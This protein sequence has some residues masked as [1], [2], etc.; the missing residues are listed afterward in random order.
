[1][2]DFQNVIGKYLLNREKNKKYLALLLALC[3]LVS[4]A[5]P[6]SLIQPADSLTIDRSHLATQLS[7]APSRPAN[8]NGWFDKVQTEVPDNAFNFSDKITATTV[9]P[10]DG[11]SVTDDGNGNITIQGGGAAG[12]NVNFAI[13]YTANSDTVSLEHPCIYYQLPEGVTVPTEYYGSAMGVIDPDYSAE[14]YAGY[15]TISKDGLIVIQFTDEYINYLSTTHSYTG[16]I[17]FDGYVVAGESASGDRVLEIGNTTITVDFDEANYNIHKQATNVQNN[18]NGTAT[19]TWQVKVGCYGNN[20]WGL[21]NMTVTDAKFPADKNSVTINPSGWGSWNGNTYTFNQFQGGYGQQFPKEATFTFTE[22]VTEDQLNA[23]YSSD[24]KKLQNTASYRYE[25]YNWGGGTTVYENTVTAD[26][27]FSDTTV[28]KGGTPDYMTGPM[29]NKVNWTITLDNP[30]GAN[31]SGYKISDEMLKKAVG[32]ITVLDASGNAVTYDATDIANGNIVLGTTDASK[33][34]IKYQTEATIGQTYNNTVEVKYPNSENAL[35]KVPASVEYSNPYI[36]DKNA[37]GFD[38]ES[39]KAF[40][41]VTVKTKADTMTLANHTFTDD[42]F[43]NISMNDLEVIYV[44]SGSNTSLT[45]TATD[46]SISF[47]DYGML[48]KSGST[49]SIADGAQGGLHEIKLRYSTTISDTDI[50]NQSTVSNDIT[51]ASGNTDTAYNELKTPYTLNKSGSYDASTQKVTWTIT[52]KNGASNTATLNGMVLTDAA[53]AD[54]FTKNFT[55]VHAYQPS[56]TDIGGTQ[57]GDVVTFGNGSTMTLSGTTLTFANVDGK[58]VNEVKFTYQTDVSSADMVS[59]KNQTNEVTANK[60]VTGTTK[61]EVQVNNP[62]QLDKTGAFDASTGEVVWTVTVKNTAQNGSLGGV[63]LTDEAFANIDA[64]KIKITTSNYN[65]NNA[66]YTVSGNTITFTNGGTATFDGNTLTFSE[67][68]NVGELV[69]QYTTKVSDADFKNQVAQTNK[70]ED[71]YGHVKEPSVAV[72][73]PYG[74]TKRG[75]F[76]PATG[77]ITWTVEVTSDANSSLNGYVLTDEAFKDLVNGIN[78]TSA[79]SYSRGWEENMTILNSAGSSIGVG[80]QGFWIDNTNRDVVFATVNLDAAAGTVT[81]TN[82]N[83]SNSQYV[84]IHK[85]TFTYETEVD[86][87]DIV[88]QVTQTNRISDNKGHVAEFPVTPT[89][90][91]QLSKSGQYDGEHKG[92]YWIIQ[93]KN[94]GKGTIAGVELTDAKFEGLTIE[95]FEVLSAGLDGN[96]TFTAALNAEKTAINIKINGAAAGSIFMSAE[97]K[98][99]VSDDA[100]FD[101]LR[102]RYYKALTDEELKA[103]HA[104]NTVTD[105]KTDGPASASVTVSSPYTL[106]KGGS[107]NADEGKINWNINAGINSVINTASLDK[108]VLTDIMLARLTSVDE[109][110][111]TTASYNGTTLTVMSRDTANN[112]ITLGANNTEYATMTFDFA[113]GTV[114]FADKTEDGLT[115]LSHVRLEYQ[116]TP[117]ADERAAGKA[118]NTVYSSDKS[119]SAEVPVETRSSLNKFF[120]TPTKNETIY[121]NDGEARNLDWHLELVED[122]GFAAKEFLV[123]TLTQST[124]GSHYI[125]KAQ[126]D[127]IIIA[128]GVKAADNYNETLTAGTDYVIKF[129]D[130]SGAEITEWTDTTTAVKFTIDFNE[131]VDTQNLRYMKVAYKTTAD[132]SKI[133]VDEN[134]VDKVTANFGND[135]TFGSKSDTDNGFY[136]ERYPA[137]YV[138]KV[139]ITAEKYWQDNS[140]YTQSGIQVQLYQSLAGTDNWIAYGD[141]VTLTNAKNWKHTWENL[142]KTETT[143]TTQYLYKVEE[144]KVDNY[145]TSYNNNGGINSGTIGITN[146]PLPKV[147]KVYVASTGEIRG[148]SEVL[149]KDL[150]TVKINNVDYYIMQWKI[151]PNPMQS[152][153]VDTLPAGFTLLTDSN[154]TEKVYGPFVGESWGAENSI[155]GWAQTVTYQDNGT[156]V[157]FKIDDGAKKYLRYFLKIPVA[158]LEKQ[159]EDNNGSIP[160]TNTVKAEGGQENPVTIT[161]SETASS[162]DEGKD[163]LTK[164]G[165][166]TL[167]PGRLKYTILVNPDGKNLSNGDTIDIHDA[168]DLLGYTGLSAE[169]VAALNASLSD[170]RVEEVSVAEDMSYSVLRALSSSEYQYTLDYKLSEVITTNYNFTETDKTA[171]GTNANQE[172]IAT[173]CTPGDKITVV[174][175]AEK[176]KTSDIYNIYLQYRGQWSDVSI[177]ATSTSRDEVAGTKTFVYTIPEGVTT[178]YLRSWAGNDV[179]ITSITATSTRTETTT[180]DLNISVPDERPLLVTYYYDITGVDLKNNDI[181]KADNTASFDTGNA[182][183]SDTADKDEFVVVSTG[184]TVTAN[185]SPVIKKTSTNDYSLTLN[186]ATFKLAY[187][188]AANGWVFA[189]GATEATSGNTT[190]HTPVWDAEANDN[191][192]NEKFIPANAYAFDIGTISMKLDEGKL[193]K[194]IETDVPEAYEGSNLLED[195]DKLLAKYKSAEGLAD[196]YQALYGNYMAKFVE[197]Y[198]STTNATFEQLLQMHL[199]GVT[200]GP[201]DNFFNNFQSTFYFTYGSAEYAAPSEFNE[202]VMTVPLSGTLSLTNSML[203]NVKASKSWDATISDTDKANATVTLK[204]YWS[205]VRKSSGFPDSMNLAT[206]ADLGLVSE[207]TNEQTIGEGQT[208]N[209]DELPAGINGR[210]IYY[211]V[212]ETAYTIGGVTYTLDEATGHYVAES[213]AQ[214]AYK[215]IYVGNGSSG[216]NADVTV[217]NTKG[218]SIGKVWKNSDNSLMDADQIPLDAVPVKLFGVTGTGEAKRETL[219]DTFTLTKDGGWVL[220]VDDEQYNLT[221][222]TSFRVEEALES[223]QLYGYAISYTYN[224][225]GPSGYIEVSNKDNTPTEVDVAVTKEWADG[226]AH[227]NDSITVNL[228]RTTTY[229]SDNGISL[230]ESNAE[231]VETVT[232]NAGNSW[233]KSWENLDYKSSNN[234]RYFYYPVEV[235]P[236]GYAANYSRIETAAKQEA[237]ITNYVPGTL[238]L[239]KTWQNSEGVAISGNSALLPESITLEIYR[240]LNVTTAAADPPVNL[241]AYAFG[242]SITTLNGSFQSGKN[243]SNELKTLM[244]NFGYTNISFDNEAMDG[245]LIEQITSSMTVLTSDYKLVTVLAGTNNLLNTNDTM[246]QMQTKMSTLIDTVYSKAASDTVLFVCAIPRIKALDWYKRE[247]YY[248]YM[249]S[250]ADTLATYQAKSDTLVNDY[251]TMVKNLVATYKANGKNIVFVDTKTAVGD[252]LMDGCHPNAAGQQAIADTLFAAINTYYGVGTTEAPPTDIDSVP[253]DL[254]ASELYKTVT[255]TPDADGN[256]KLNLELEDKAADGTE[257]IYYVKEANTGTDYNPTYQ[258]NGQI[259][260]DTSETIKIGNTIDVAKTEI[261]V[262]KVWLDGNSVS[263]PEDISLTLQRSA[264]GGTTW[265]PVNASINWNKSV[266]PWV[267]TYSNLE[268]SDSNGNFFTYKVTETVPDGY[269]VSYSDPDGILLSEN[270]SADDRTMTITNSAVF[271]L[272]V[273]KLWANGAD[274]NNGKTV[275]IKIHRAIADRLTGSALMLALSANTLKVQTGSEGKVTANNT[276]ITAVSDDT[277]V[278]TVTVDGKNITIHGVKEGTATITVKSGSETETITVTVSDAP[279]LELTG[280][281]PAM[282]AGQTQQLTAKMSDDSTIPGTVTYSSSDS[283]VATVNANGVVSAVNQGEVTITATNGAGLTATYTINVS[284]SDTLALNADKTTIYIGG[285]AKVTPDPIYGTFGYESLNP[286]IASVN[287][288]GEVTGLSAGTATIRVTRNDGKKATVDIVVEEVPLT[289]SPESVTVKVDETAEL[290]ANKTLTE[291][292]VT[293]SANVEI[294]S[295][296]GDTITIKGVTA[297]SATVTVNDGVTPAKTVSVTVKAASLVGGPLNVTGVH[298]IVLDDT[299]EVE[300]ITVTVDLSSSWANIKMYVLNDGNVLVQDENIYW[301][302][303]NDSLYYGGTTIGGSTFTMTVNGTADTLRFAYKDGTCP[304]T[305]YTVTYKSENGGSSGTT[306]PEGSDTEETTTTTTT[307][308]EE[309]PTAKVQQVTGLKPGDTL[310]VTLSG[311]VPNASVNG[312]YGYSYNEWTQDEWNGTFDSSG[313]LTLTYTVPDTCTEGTHFEFQIWSVNGGNPQNVT[314]ETSVSSGSSGEE[315]G[316]SGGSSETVVLTNVQNNV[317]YDLSSYNYQDIKAIK[318]TFT[319]EVPDWATGDLCWEEWTSIAKFS[320]SDVVNG[321]FIVSVS[322]PKSSMTVHLY[323]GQVLSSVT[324]Y[325]VDPT[326]LTS[327]YSLRSTTS[328]TAKLSRAASVDGGTLE[329]VNN[330][331]SITLG[332]S[333][334][335]EKIISDLPVCDADGNAYYYWIEEEPVAGFTP[336]YKFEDGDTVTAD[337]DY[338]INAANPG[339]NPTAIVKNTPDE[340]G[341]ASMPSTG[342]SGTTGYYGIGVI[343]IL[344]SAAGYLLLRRRQKDESK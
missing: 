24:S 307:T 14:K 69:F 53:F 15:Y 286:T 259:L 265:E 281:A 320:G 339:D 255:I 57:S 68:A 55:L 215:P 166:A 189:T 305:S 301:W 181:I 111:V 205:T 298:D 276:G 262:N 117:T 240:R 173:N 323:N 77:T 321:S 239:E 134:A 245:R 116:T 180:A 302:N 236:D 271:N 140:G 168:F 95:D 244:S 220:T 272:K 193:Y 341:G 58:G 328:T 137:D 174:L 39:K 333:D 87:A 260:G 40:W 176:L 212:K 207:F 148:G 94:E 52:V 122:S 65:Y 268:L 120:D 30:Y 288:N 112:T 175:T 217:T 43:A 291:D 199:K 89:N 13:T 83:E 2:K 27:T 179:N 216:S 335:W 127:A 11:N 338:C 196:T 91:F 48:T 105:N 54:L 275:T 118:S 222:Y 213:G 162:G 218:L 124:S 186:D 158:D 29:Q 108:T 194:I 261:Y 167:V 129:Y 313:N 10:K 49:I 280:T 169:Q 198:P 31:L 42:A 92:A 315:P 258:N 241:K 139:S 18:G 101:D 327:N 85:L 326:T 109:I 257:Y 51:D 294:V 123:D 243:Y 114:T 161:V 287:N 295:V 164:E 266:T 178:V 273:S 76:N 187:Y 132:I 151:I 285:T 197:A 136:F 254:T 274:L 81:I 237:T 99:V 318:L 60:P 26:A 41:E 270:A 195:F 191:T 96:Y 292:M 163:L 4:F 104:S 102:V 157:T 146:T 208:A 93:T 330:V 234:K 56:Y 17:N 251:N 79:K 75:Q 59:G 128:G 183:A 159:M 311:G 103:G 250:D 246:D 22:T 228:W 82:G 314:I 185:K 12:I 304:I 209:W 28:T 223:N 88:G 62:F 154:G 21:W 38:P 269:K 252:Q 142:P 73:N 233:T 165:A 309:E 16:T 224:T 44:R 303:A 312:C 35:P 45:A 343:M 299:R 206:A 316:G 84:G 210:P 204:L 8:S 203:M 71:N 284:L 342:G 70:I 293:A 332:A 36:L 231:L 145:N 200:G 221:P 290:K 297:G 229:Q 152:T 135:V 324:L 160:V 319:G 63:I 334:S 86:A 192:T 329:F 125:T 156:S 115:G 263:R 235:V 147:D 344:G 23:I 322:D 202:T 289:V 98:L 149:L 249:Q 310:T 225:N 46:S 144:F 72:T 133:T 9:T 336:S 119:A 211:Y 138:E 32:T 64:T 78:V 337:Q 308:T 317:V 25:E 227:A 5:V 1:M 184:A 19:V 277:S 283:N 153:V 247:G 20:M 97:G 267:G 67:G 66:Q 331:A 279:V 113:A 282:T 172:F 242:D 143:R 300:S 90:P 107:Y 141:P 100:N 130:A 74:L 34:V 110:N 226:E 182:S 177:D 171:T 37:S 47:G 80:Y 106:E 155:V 131:S 306:A 61:Y 238:N 278:A 188:T 248:C 126:A 219:I 296:E 121:G 264:D 214:G 33:V 3:L 232:L 325:Y 150:Q 170:I 253:E 6:Y 230:N 190:T 7:G 50:A 201:Y 340:T 256:W